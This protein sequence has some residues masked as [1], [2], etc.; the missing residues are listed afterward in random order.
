MAEE[1]GP[2]DVMLV[3]V[4]ALDLGHSDEVLRQQVSVVRPDAPHLRQTLIAVEEELLSLLLQLLALPR[5][6]ESKTLLLVLE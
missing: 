1:V 5:Q 6:H 2:H 4:G 3:D